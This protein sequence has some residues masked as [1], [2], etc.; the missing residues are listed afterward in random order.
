MFKYYFNPKNLIS[1]K[2]KDLL[3]L[4]IIVFLTIFSFFGFGFL[5]TVLADGSKNVFEGGVGLYEEC[6]FDK[7]RLGVDR[8]WLYSSQHVLRCFAAWCDAVGYELP[9]HYRV[10]SLAHWAARNEKLYFEF[11]NWFYSQKRWTAFKCLIACGL[12]L[13]F[14]VYFYP[15][16]P[17]G[18]TVE[19]KNADVKCL[20]TSSSERKSTDSKN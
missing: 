6:F 1:W 11:E 3:A 17:D 9:E 15:D 14:L 19:I 10:K 16:G 5:D 20:E 2:N 18:G 8:H 7:Q 4:E 12:T 13:A